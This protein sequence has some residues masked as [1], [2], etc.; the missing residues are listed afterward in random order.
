M[1]D[2]QLVGL[3]SLLA[4]DGDHARALGAAPE[5]PLPAAVAGGRA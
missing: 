2:E 4:V 1:L 3:A 5:W